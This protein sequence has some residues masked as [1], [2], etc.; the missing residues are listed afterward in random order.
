[1]ENQDQL[2]LLNHIGNELKLLW[3]QMEAWQEL[4]DVEQEKRRTLIQATAPGFFTLVQITLAESILMRIS[5]LMDPPR[6]NGRDNV[7]ISSLGDA[8]SDSSHACLHRRIQA[9]TDEWSKKD[10]QTK[11]EQGKYAN[12]KILRNKW[13]AHNDTTQRQDQP[14]DSLWIPL[15]HEDFAL[16]LQLA[17][18]LWL[19]YKQAYKTLHG[20]D[21]VPPIHSCLEDRSAMILKA[22]CR[23]VL[24]NQMLDNSS[25]REQERL[26][27]ALTKIESEQLG[28]DKLREVFPNK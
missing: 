27:A 4:F 3:W 13:L 20:P 15:M 23:S 1:M 28:E 6:S 26:L 21:V 17:R 16:A 12:L 18:E 14:L 19:I 11:T 9:L 10:T 7:A 25:D 2:L 22:L 5:R 24:L 8:F